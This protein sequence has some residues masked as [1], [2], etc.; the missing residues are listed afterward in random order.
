MNPYKHSKIILTKE[1]DAYFGLLCSTHLYPLTGNC[2][3]HYLSKI[4]RII[5]VYG[6]NESYR[7]IL[8]ACD[9]Q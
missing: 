4:H 1:N 5:L 9:L 8:F 3:Q 6:A 2:Q 7:I